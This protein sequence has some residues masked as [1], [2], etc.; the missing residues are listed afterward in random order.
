MVC[1]VALQRCSPCNTLI[2]FTTICLSPTMLQPPTRPACQVLTMQPNP[3]YGCLVFPCVAKGSRYYEEEGVESNILQV[4]ILFADAGG[5]GGREDTRRRPAHRDVARGW[6]T[7][8]GGGEQRPK[9]A[10]G[11]HGPPLPADA[12]P[13][14][15]EMQ[16]VFPNASFAG[17]FCNGEIGP[18][19]PDELEPAGGPVARMMGYSTGGGAW[20]WA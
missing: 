15:P 19:P 17:S 4:R 18:A 3:V 12:S 20:K 6:G 8:V 13:P 7:A 1:G 5:C 16:D 2:R 11:L 14:L 9:A 10:R